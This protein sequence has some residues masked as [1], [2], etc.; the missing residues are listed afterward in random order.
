MLAQKRQA[1]MEQESALDL[2][3][4]ALKQLEEELQKKQQ[5]LDSSF[6]LLDST[7]L[8]HPTILGRWNVVMTCTETTCA[9]SAV[10]DTK[11]E[12]WEITY[13]QNHL[14][15]K[16]MAGNKVVRIYTGENSKNSVIELTA[17]VE[18]T[19]SVQATKIVVRLNPADKNSVGGK[20]EILREG[21]CRIVYSL[22]LT[23]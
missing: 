1:L 20:R 18:G 6:I 13:E 3:A 22:T 9:G 4:K 21:G 7:V 5:Q 17:T 23:R 11:T 12:I 10:G 15:A 2:R 8:H 19:E 16:A 14:V